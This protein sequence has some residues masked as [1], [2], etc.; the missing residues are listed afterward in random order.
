MSMELRSEMILSLCKYKHA[1]QQN[2]V[3]KVTR[4]SNRVMTNKIQSNKNKINT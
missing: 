3:H 2:E 4:V 1:K